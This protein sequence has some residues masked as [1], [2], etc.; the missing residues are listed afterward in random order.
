MKS[1][2]LTMLGILAIASGAA[3]AK[4]ENYGRNMASAC[5][6]CHGT[7]GNSVGGMEPLAGLPKNKLVTNMKEFRAG[8]KSATVMH[9]LAKGYNDAQIEAI[10]DFYAAQK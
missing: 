6:S 10:A 7:N 2:Y 8:A 1:R 9:Q 4:D 5:N 3:L